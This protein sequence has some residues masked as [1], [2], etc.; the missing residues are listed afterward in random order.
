[1]P[2]SLRSHRQVGR[3]ARAALGP[4]AEVANQP[5]KRF[6]RIHSPSSPQAGAAPVCGRSCPRFSC[7]F[8]TCSPARRDGVHGTDPAPVLMI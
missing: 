8:F 3:V 2:A 7:T 6:F 5:V 1:M 4:T